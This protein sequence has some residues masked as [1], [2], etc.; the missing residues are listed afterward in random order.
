MNKS[1]QA[2]LFYGKSKAPIAFS[3]Y[4]LYQ[5]GTGYIALYDEEDGYCALCRI[6]DEREISS[7]VIMR[8]RLV[9]SCKAES[10]TLKELSVIIVNS[11]V[12]N[13]EEA[14]KIIESCLCK[15]R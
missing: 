9:I 4:K 14:D 2:I 13:L 15:E 11:E 3:Q 7:E 1:K 10:R 6:L 12:K 5:I 8:H